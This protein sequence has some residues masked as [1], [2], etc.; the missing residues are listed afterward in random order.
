[1]RCE[2]IEEK[3]TIGSNNALWWKTLNS[4]DKKVMWE[5]LWERRVPSR[6]AARFDLNYCINEGLNYRDGAKL[7]RA[8]LWVKLVKVRS[9]KQITFYDL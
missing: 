2:N 7:Q 1:M 9:G 5:K 8:K 6:T 4:G 3:S